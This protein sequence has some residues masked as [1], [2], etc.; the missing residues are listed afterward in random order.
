MYIYH[1]NIYV[2]SFSSFVLKLNLYTIF[3]WILKLF[4][5]KA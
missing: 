4:L 3:I 1:L 5:I 2:Y